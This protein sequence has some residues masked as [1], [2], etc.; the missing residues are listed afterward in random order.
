[1]TL[2]R[3]R[4]TRDLVNVHD[5]MDRLFSDFFGTGLDRGDKV[6]GTV[7]NPYVDIAET[8]DEIM[9]SAELPGIG[10]DDVKISLHDNTLILRGEKKQQNQE[11]KENYHRVE[12]SYGAF[13]RSI[14]LPAATESNK[15]KAKFKDGVLRITLPKKEEA[16]LKE[17]P[18]SVE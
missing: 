10:K 7:W 18:I 4:P 12:R 2:V 13:Q 9:V 8:D 14:S 5:A 3:W 16:K 17:I 11:K 6:L 15:I 1:M